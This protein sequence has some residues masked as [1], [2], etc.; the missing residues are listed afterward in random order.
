MVG[1]KLDRNSLVDYALRT[2]CNTS[3]STDVEWAIIEPFM[4]RRC[5]I[6]ENFTNASSN[7]GLQFGDTYGTGPGGRRPEA[8]LVLWIATGHHPGS[9]AA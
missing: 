5:H 4:P 2:S 6:I 9:M 3:D 7:Q 1:E 8:R